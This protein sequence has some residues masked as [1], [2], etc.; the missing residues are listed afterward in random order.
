MTKQSNRSK[1]NKARSKR[2]RIND[3]KLRG[4]KS[5]GKKYSRKYSGSKTLKNITGILDGNK[6]GFGFVRPDT[7]GLEDVFIPSR[8]LG[9]A[10]HGD[11]VEI[12]VRGPEDRPSGEVVRIIEMKKT[13]IG[14]FDGSLIKPQSEKY[15]AMVRIHPADSKNASPGDIVTAHITKRTERGV[16]GKIVEVIGGFEDP[17]IESK[18][19]LRSRGFKEEFPEEVKKEVSSVPKTVRKKDLENRTDLRNVFTITIDPKT[20]KD[21]DDALAIKKQKKGYKLWVSIADVS[22]YV[23]P[24]T[25]LDTEAYERATSVYFPDRSIP[26][27]PHELSSGIC[28]LKPKVNRLAMTVEMDFDERGKR[29]KTKMYE[30]VINSNHR[31]TYEWVE[32]LAA[33]PALKKKHGELWTCVSLLRELASKRNNIRKRKGAIDLDMPEAEIIIDENDEVEDIVRREQTWSHKLV[34]EYMLTANETVAEHMTNKKQPMI[35][36]IHEKPDPGSIEKLADILA[37]HGIQLLG[38]GS[39]PLN[40]KPKDY[41]RTINHAKGTKHE[42]AVKMLCLRSMMQARYSEVLDIHFGLASNEYSHFTSPIRR[43][44]DLIVHRL[45]KRLMQKG[46]KSGKPKF[47]APQDL[48]TA[49]MHCSERERSST[50]AEREMNSFYCAKWASKRI[51][52]IF[53]G[54]ISGLTGHALFV[55]LEEVFVEGMVP[56]E[57]I[58]YEVNYLEDRMIME[59]PSGNYQMGDQV[60]VK[61]FSVDME[62]KKIILLI[63]E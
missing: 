32:K 10:L 15:G 44:P 56:A 59:T 20:A 63:M 58:D 23:Q 21:F 61:I 5:T 35:Y 57:T 24:G 43:Y 26:M 53:N 51:G 25:P 14:T 1:K 39:E 6:K 42:T 45:L 47:A 40:I 52:Q 41:Q 33:S 38:K 37:T 18:L 12:R 54:V 7:P 36:R 48:K 62:R 30:A 28:S 49:A 4:R 11:R 29:T 8:L 17:K 50:E 9:G 2:D 46:P 19:A 55:E 3:R 22:Y 27:L 13:V 31:L 34:E 60:K 16:F